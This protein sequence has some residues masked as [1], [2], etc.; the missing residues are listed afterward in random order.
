MKTVSIISIFL[1]LIVAGQSQAG[2]FSLVVN[3]HAS[4]LGKMYKTTNYAG[5]YKEW[6]C[7]EN[8]CMFNMEVEAPKT[9]KTPINLNEKNYGFGFEYEIQKGWFYNG[10]FYIDS[11]NKPQ[12]YA[13]GGKYWGIAQAH[14]LTLRAGLIGGL[15]THSQVMNGKTPFPGLLPV[16]E[17]GYKQ[18][19]LNISY[20]PAFG[21]NDVSL[22]WFQLKVTPK[23]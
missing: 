9:V 21:G 13:G 8:G 6:G 20:V 7:N 16:L 22:I 1:F 4:H 14:S 12:Y 10:G 3:G 19:K 23:L 5:K 15:M 2:D 17:A 11:F 18:A